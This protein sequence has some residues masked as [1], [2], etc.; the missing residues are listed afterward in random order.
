MAA[1]GIT[2]DSLKAQA[3]KLLA[4]TGNPDLQP[5]AIANQASAAAGQLST[6][7]AGSSGSL[8]SDDLQG[9]LQN[10]I[11]LGKSTVD[12]ADKDSVINVVIART[13][14]SR[15]VAEQRVEA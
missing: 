14:V 2:L 9:A 12:Q 8:P 10:I 1:S 13:G 7:A 4:Q 3:Q 15:A 11:S 5:G 6:A